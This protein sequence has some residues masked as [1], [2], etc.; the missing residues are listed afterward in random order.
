MHCKACDKL[1]SDFEATRKY[2]DGTFVDLCKRDFDSIA[3]LVKVV[4][5]EDLRT[6]QP[7]DDVDEP[8]ADESE[9]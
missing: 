8:A 7:I 9:D 6:E 5:R 3:H 2:A 1:L 4:E